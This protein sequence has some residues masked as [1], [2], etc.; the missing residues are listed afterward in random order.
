MKIV[1]YANALLLAGLLCIG[2]VAHAANLSVDFTQNPTAFNADANWEFGFSSTATTF[3]GQYIV[4][5]L[6]TT[7][8]SNIAIVDQYTGEVLNE[9]LLNY[10]WDGSFVETFSGS[11]V[12]GLNLPTV[13]PGFI[14]V[15]AT[16]TPVELSSALANFPGFLTLQVTANSSP[17]PVPEPATFEL[18]GLGIAGLMFGRRYLMERIS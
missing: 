3:T 16:G 13:P 8:T 9:L 4:D 1:S 12:T 10:S 14:S 11:V 5:N 17:A 18:F 15:L 6:G 2:T 7:G